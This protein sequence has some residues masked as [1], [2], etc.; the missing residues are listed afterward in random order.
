[1]FFF[2]LARQAGVS[3]RCAVAL[4]LPFLICCLHGEIKTNNQLFVVEAE[5][6]LEEQQLLESVLYLI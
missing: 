3:V 2:S 6:A 5:C 1:M 4:S